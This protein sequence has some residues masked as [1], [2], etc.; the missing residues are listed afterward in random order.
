V[1][2][3]SSRSETVSTGATVVRPCRVADA[4]VD[5]SIRGERPRGLVFR[6]GTRPIRPGVVVQRSRR[7]RMSSTATAALCLAVQE[8]FRRSLSAMGTTESEPRA[9]SR[10]PSSPTAPLDS[11]TT[12]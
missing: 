9:N 2:E 1:R 4:Y 11:Q 12:S 8:A 6:V 10:M 3:G 5:G 7:H